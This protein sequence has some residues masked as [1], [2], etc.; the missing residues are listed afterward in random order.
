LLYNSI[1][2]GSK[3]NTNKKERLSMAN[4]SYQELET[5]AI[6]IQERRDEIQ[7]I[8]QDS[9]GKIGG[10]AFYILSDLRKEEEV[11]FSEWK[12]IKFEMIK[13][14]RNAL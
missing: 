12:A 14:N 5:K 3:Q 2:R 7:K 8:F 4:L 11:L 13:R 1:I 6:S 10:I 9:F